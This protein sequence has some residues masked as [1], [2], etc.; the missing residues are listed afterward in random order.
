[1][2]QKV[3]QQYIK[4]ATEIE[5]IRAASKLAAQTLEMITNEISIG[6]TTNQ[7]DKLCHDFIVSN[8]ARPACLNYGGF[9]KSICTSVNHVVCHGIP[10]D[11]ALKSGD[12]VN[13]DLVVEL[14]GYHG[15]TSKMFTVGAPSVIAKRLIQA[16][17]ECLY[18]GIY[19]VKPGI[20]LDNIGNAIEKHARTYRYNVVRDFCGHGIGAKMHEEPE[21]VHYRNGNSGVILAPGMVFTI[22]PMINIG[23]SRIKILKDG[24]TVITKDRKLSAQMEHTILVTETGFEILTLRQEEN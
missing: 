19:Q 24:W 12:I 6:M 3:N 13:V 10:D 4:S 15:D 21:V 9:P 17:K 5:K 7:L 20:P 14:D 1:M 11:K 22:E 18:E 2:L 8:N 23:D 16:T